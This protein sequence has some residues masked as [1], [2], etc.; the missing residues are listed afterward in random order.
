MNLAMVSLV[1]IY[2]V[3]KNTVWEFTFLGKIF[4]KW[5]LNSTQESSFYNPLSLRVDKD[6]VVEQAGLQVGDL[7]LDVNG[8]SFESI[9]HQAAVDFMKSQHRVIMRVKV[10]TNTCY[11]HFYNIGKAANKIAINTNFLQSTGILPAAKLIYS[12][13]S[14]VYPHGAEANGK[15]VYSSRHLQNCS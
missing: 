4:S 5:T 1:S 6:S 9:S 10:K 14:W 8:T 13:V 12:D 2:V 11:H 7:I 3:E 15:V